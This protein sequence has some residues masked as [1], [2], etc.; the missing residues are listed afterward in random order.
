[1]ARDE[2]AFDP[3]S[4][5]ERGEAGILANEAE[6]DLADGELTLV[7]NSPVTNSREQIPVWGRATWF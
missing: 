1:M 2:C 5:M 3:T 6:K 4:R 7:P